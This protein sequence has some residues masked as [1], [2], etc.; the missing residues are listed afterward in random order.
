MCFTFKRLLKNKTYIFHFSQF[1]LIPGST[2]RRGRE[3]QE[4]SNK[5]YILQSGVP[6]TITGI[7]V[8]YRFIVCL[9]IYGFLF[10]PFPASSLDIS[11]ILAAGAG[12]KIVMSDVTM[13]LKIS[14]T[15]HSTIQHHV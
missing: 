6:Y 4:G 13:Y 10:D 2:W 8:T 3:L 1:H 12:H 5:I 15:L 14:F 9:V 11:R 7:N